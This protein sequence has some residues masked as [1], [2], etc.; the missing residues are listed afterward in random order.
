MDPKKSFEKT[1]DLL[2]D[3]HEW[4]HN[5]VNLI[6]SEN[7][8]SPAVKEALISD[9]GNRY[10]EGVPKERLY[11]GCEYIDEVEMLAMD[12]AKEVYGAEHANVQPVS[13]VL[14]NLATYTAF[15]D[16]GDT[17]M[18]LPISSGGH[19][20]MGKA[21]FGGT[22]GAVHG[23]NIEYL[24]FD[25]EKMNVD[26]E[27]AEEKIREVEPDLLLFGASVFLFPHPVKELSEVAKNHGA[28][29]AYDAAHVAGL[30]GGDHFQDPLSEGADVMDCSTHKTL[31]GPQHGMVLTSDESL[32][33]DI[34]NAVFPGVVSNHHL[35]SVAGVAIALAEHLEFGEAY[36]NQIIKNA[37]AL[38]ESL[39]ERGLDVVGSEK[40]FTS[41]H[42]VLVDVTDYGLGGDFE[43]KLEKANLI[44]NRN[45]LPWDVR[46]DRHF[47]NPGGIR[48]GVSEVTRLGMEEGEME[49]IADYIS[50]VVVEDED[51]KEVGEDVSS[52]AEDYS[53][54]HY[55]FDSGAE[56]Y[57]Y[58]EVR[59]F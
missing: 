24:P 3:H 47:D 40:G 9:F 52:F 15:T 35:H 7:V 54:L 34:D 29:V 20:S 18:C 17:L 57:D 55:C 23:L 33:S 27:K 39:Y 8:P 51:P 49:V 25:E 6:A 46:E 1:L 43:R 42:I 21:K 56:A 4:T 14:A 53:Q 31:P 28:K 11:A 36:A 41:S 50:R 30:I 38:A 10:A 22:A 37:K 48:M 19:I 58:I 16:P 12:L 5:T 59:D 26:V 32:K 13:G 44:L 45:L 2:K